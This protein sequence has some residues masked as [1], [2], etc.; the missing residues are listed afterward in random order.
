MRLR[1]QVN[2][3]KVR[4][5]LV[6]AAMMSC[7]LGCQRPAVHWMFTVAEHDGGV[8]WDMTGL[9]LKFEGTHLSG[10]AGGGMLVYSSD[11]S[12]GMLANRPGDP[13]EFHWPPIAGKR[14]A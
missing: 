5:Y 4:L 14:P 9:C 2:M 6:T 3:E 10:G 7:L 11:E 13:E 12:E 1:L 8:V